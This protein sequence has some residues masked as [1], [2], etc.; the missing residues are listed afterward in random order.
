MSEPSRASPPNVKP[1]I[2]K[3]AAFEPLCAPSAQDNVKFA[4]AD[5][6]QAK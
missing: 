3:G 1:G 4:L 2:H 5:N 6:Q